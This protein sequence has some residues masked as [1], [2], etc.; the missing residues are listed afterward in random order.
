MEEW[1]MIAAEYDRF[2]VDAYAAPAVLAVVEAI[3]RRLPPSGRP[4]L[5]AHVTIKGTFVEPLDLDMIAERVRSCCAEAQPFTLRTGALH[6][7]ADG[8]HGG[9]W[10]AVEG[11][12]ELTTLHWRLVEASRDL[13]TTIYHGEDT[14]QFTPH[15]TLVQQI[16]AEQVKA[17][18]SV[19]E[20]FETRYAFPVSE[21]ALVGRRGGIRW[22][23]LA[24]F[25]LGSAVH[26]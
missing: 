21:L 8:P 3:R 6:G 20:R 1:V 4:I 16:P 22:E 25:P 15:L 2:A 9:A 14:G 13:C 11:P 7:W 19:I 23:T 26:S 18:V 24:T 5:P 17:A 10:L 12:P